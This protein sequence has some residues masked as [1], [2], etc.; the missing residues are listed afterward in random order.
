MY[1]RI[2]L[3]RRLVLALAAAVVAPACGQLPPSPPT[4]PPLPPTSRDADWQQ[5]FARADLLYAAGPRPDFEALGPVENCTARGCGP[6]G[7]DGKSKCSALWWPGLGNGFL[8][9]I[10]QGP[11]LRIAGLYSGDYGR[12]SA[13]KG[14][15]LPR[16]PGEFSNRQYAY[17]ASIPAFAASIIAHSPLALPGSSRAA[18]NTRDAV[19]YER[20][21]LSGGGELELRTFFHRTRR[22]LIVVEVDLDCTSCTRSA[23]VSLRAFSR[24]ELGDVVFQQKGPP[25]HAAGGGPRQLLGMLRAPENCE[26]SNAHEYDT[27][28]TLGY[29]HD[30]CPEKL[31]AQPGRKATLQLLSVL[32]LS[33]EH[34][35]DT[36]TTAGVM[37]LQNHHQNISRFTVVRKPRRA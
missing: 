19:Y 33:N 18:L 29:V 21:S 6:G 9:G 24:P 11:T 12:Y 20:S 13:Y 7:C 3:A 34:G 4:G 2:I 16:V 31:A 26:P 32:T 28:H 27:N 22:N 5:P 10:A 37:I 36:D 14:D 25:A 30:V 17:R 15:Q 8:G 23:E 35:E 1:T